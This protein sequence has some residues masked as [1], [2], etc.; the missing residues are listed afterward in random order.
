MLPPVFAALKA[1]P[2][3]MAIVGNPPRIY[4]HADAPQRPEGTPALPYVTW[5][6][7]SATPENQLSGT[8]PTDRMTLQVDCWHT[9]GKG[10]ET[11]A[12][13]V[14]DAIEP[15]AHLTAMPIDL[16]DPETKLFRIALQFDWFNDRDF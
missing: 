3:V 12:A 9:T 7:L 10:I 15:S 2:D 14:R 5:F 16:R 13:A 1:S 8:P 4:K 11:L 6:L